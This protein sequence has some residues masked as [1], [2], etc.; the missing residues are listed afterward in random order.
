[1]K[2]V[3]RKSTDSRVSVESALLNVAASQITTSMT[4]L[5]SDKVSVARAIVT[6]GSGRSTGGPG[7]PIIYNPSGNSIPHEMFKQI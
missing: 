5:G 4:Q 1:M 3:R 2:D 6:H 7:F